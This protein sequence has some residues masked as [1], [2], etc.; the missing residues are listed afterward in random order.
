MVKETAEG[1][2]PVEETA[3]EMC[4]SAEDCVHPR[5]VGVCGIEVELMQN[6][7]A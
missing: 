1:V 2:F 4:D 3:G 6:S 7:Q 5:V